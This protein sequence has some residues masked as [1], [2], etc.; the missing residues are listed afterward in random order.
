VQA[1]DSNRLAE[2][3]A[4]LV[5]NEEVIRERWVSA[6]EK[7]WSHGA[8]HKLDSFQ[9]TLARGPDGFKALTAS[10]ENGETE[11]VC[12]WN[13]ASINRIHSEAF[14]ISDYFLEVSSL[15]SVIA[16]TIVKDQD[17]SDEYR[18]DRLA[19][20][21]ECFDSLLKPIL[22]ATSNVYEYVVECGYRSLCLVDTTLTLTYANRRMATLL[23][24]PDPVGRCLLDFFDPDDHARIREAASGKLG[25]H[26]RPIDLKLLGADGSVTGVRTEIAS[27]KA[28]SAR[29]FAFVELS[30]TSYPVPMTANLLEGLEQ[31]ILRTSAEKV[32]TYAN[33]KAME[34]LGIRDFQPFAV[35]ELLVNEEAQ[36]HFDTTFAERLEGK[37]DE[38]TAWIKRRDDGRRARVRISAIPTGNETDILGS[39]AFLHDETIEFAKEALHRVIETETNPAAIYR[40]LEKELSRYLP[41]DAF[42][43]SEWSNEQT[44]AAVRYSS[45]RGE[46]QRWP[47]RWYSLTPAR[48]RWLGHDIQRVPDLE[49]WLDQDEWSTLKQD[50][51][52]Q[53]LLDLDIRSFITMPIRRE[54]HVRATVALCSIDENA[55]TPR[56]EHLVSELSINQAV[57]MAIRLTR[58]EALRFR[59]EL[60]NLLIEQETFKSIAR[61][62][63]RELANFFRWQNVSVFR[64]DKTSKRAALYCQQPGLDD[65]YELP[66]DFCQPLSK[67]IVGWVARHGKSFCAGNVH[68]DAYKDVYLPSNPHTVSELALP[69]FLDNEV[70]WVL[71]IE[72]S[73]QVAFSAES[74]RTLEEFAHFIDLLVDRIASQ[75]IVQ[76]SMEKT[77]DG[78]V[79][80]DNSG[81][82][83]KT[84]RAAREILGYPDLPD[85]NSRTAENGGPSKLAELFSKPSMGEAFVTSSAFEARRTFLRRSDGEDVKVLMSMHPMPAD[86][87]GKIFMFS[88][89]DLAYEQEWLGRLQDVFYE[90]A[91]QT[92][93]P[94]SLL[95]GWL[96]RVERAD[97]RHMAITDFAREAQTQLHKLELSYDR[98]ACFDRKMTERPSAEMLIDLSELIAEVAE[99]VS[100]G[101]SEAID[102]HIPEG[103]RYVRGDS[104]QLGF[105]FESLLSYLLR[106]LPIE[107]RISLGAVER[108]GKI[109]VT[110]EGPFGVP[111]PHEFDRGQW[112]VSRVRHEIASGWRIIKRFVRNHKGKIEVQD[113][114]DGKLTFRLSLPCAEEVQ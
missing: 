105:V 79:F 7:A 54:G 2:A 33:A 15:R 108:K 60:T 63:T 81:V 58:K 24:C 17:L 77:S 70:F 91:T 97:S 87:P 44:H 69:I 61:T 50:K 1:I 49:S 14:S 106:N 51:G 40:A 36:T 111:N 103:L 86:M 47:S 67:G 76:S 25:D 56:D 18:A 34:I 31:G 83:T 101:E 13:N 107:G 62:A 30:E 10:L 110:I 109:Q 84:S 92:K 88:K 59:L 93:T 9:A 37:P 38:Y 48:R 23:R 27:L 21:D 12:A 98:L 96:R 100:S 45:L 72:D 8:R 39:I 66:K 52:V 68:D 65:G 46:E 95:Y 26:P 78:I 89:L 28:A 94:L 75:A 11:V 6:L 85:E 3:K 113:P 22:D 71:N 43:V 64:I 53:Q 90:V 32:I 4:C 41:I 29:S 42:F 57:M 73:Q 99:V 80:T 19:T 102:N 35:K 74:I 112:D 20:I 114:G 55:Y 82:I 5:K 16:D 104:Y